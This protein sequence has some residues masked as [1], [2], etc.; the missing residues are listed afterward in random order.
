[1]IK[2]K[3]GLASRMWEN[4][5]RHPPFSPFPCG[6]L[7]I[8][9]FQQCLALIG[10]QFGVGMEVC[11]IVISIRAQEDIIAVWTRTCSDRG[12][13]QKIRFVPATTPPPPSPLPARLTSPF[14]FYRE[15]MKKALNVN[16]STEMEYKNHNKSLQDK[17]HFR[18]PD[19][20]R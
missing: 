8:Y 4:L 1:M 6:I 13:L 3:K 10:E 5:V 9:L 19:G 17:A 11:G 14:F 18:N 16:Q 2:L 7:S 20:A 15:G 12:L